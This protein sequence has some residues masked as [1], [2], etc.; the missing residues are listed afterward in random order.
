MTNAEALFQRHIRPL[1]PLPTGL[2]PDLT[3]MQPF[4]ALLFDVYGTLLISGAGELGFDQIPPHHRDALRELLGQHGIDRTPQQLC[5][6]LGQ[7]IDRSHADSRRRG[8]DYPEV[9]IVSIWAEVLGSGDRPRLMRFAMA[10]ELTVNPVYP[11]P[12]VHTL[13]SACKALAM[14]LGIISN[15]QFYT[16]P[17][18]A[19]LL[20]SA[21]REALDSRLLF[22]SWRE[23]CAKP[24][25]VMFERAKT[26]LAGMGISAASVVYVGNDMRTDLVPAAA[27]GFKTALFAGDRRSLRRRRSERC[28]RS[29]RPDLIITDLRQL[30]AGIRKPSTGGF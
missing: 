23:G 2:V 15:A 13:L 30:I 14:P 11:M 5:Q 8:I 3:H 28:C 22:F 10:F 20:G 19:H 27:V 17:L 4:A 21:D 16:L 7:A 25:P 6:D 29:F 26:A 12:G 18:L 9:D 1:A 24:S